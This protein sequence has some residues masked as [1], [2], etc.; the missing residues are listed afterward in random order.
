[1]AALMPQEVIQLLVNLGSGGILALFFWWDRGRLTDE[2]K[3]LREELRAINAARLV[4][5]RETGK[6]TVTALMTA[7][8]NARE[9]S[10]ELGRLVEL[11]RSMVVI[12]QALKEAFDRQGVR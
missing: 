10:Q 8:T 9:S 12:L 1:M 3:A 5:L 6:E 2:I 7:A 11:I 4:E